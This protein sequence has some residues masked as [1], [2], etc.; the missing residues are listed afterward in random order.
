MPVAY[1]GIVDALIGIFIL[2]TVAAAVLPLVVNSTGAL[3]SAI[4]AL[5]PGGAALASLIG[6]LATLFVIRQILSQ[7]RA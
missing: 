1:E 4:A 5:I 7:V 6:V 2:V 3:G